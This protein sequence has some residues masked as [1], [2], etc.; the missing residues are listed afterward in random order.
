MAYVR[1]NAGICGFTA[2]VRATSEDRQHVAIEVS[3]DCPD[4]I[5]IAKALG[6]E[7]FDA[8]REIGPCAQPG[9]M[10]ETGIMRICGGLPHVACPVPAGICKCVE[11]AAGLALPRDA[12]IE[13]RR[14][15]GE[16]P[17]GAS[18]GEG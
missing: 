6:A 5:R 18:G 3:S 4:V 7:E 10:Y 14:E 13:V 16:E 1:I 17:P 12:R 2:E 8:F 9:S 11:V 15:P